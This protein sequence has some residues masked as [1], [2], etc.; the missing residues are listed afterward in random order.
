VVPWEHQY[1]LFRLFRRVSWHLSHFSTRLMQEIVLGMKESNA[2]LFRS[3]KQEL[4][5]LNGISTGQKTG[6]PVLS[7]WSSLCL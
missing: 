6:R 1:D 3:A 2:W 4:V 7:Q 5:S